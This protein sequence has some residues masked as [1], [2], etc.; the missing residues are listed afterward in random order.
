MDYVM[1]YVMDYSDGLCEASRTVA[2][3]NSCHWNRLLR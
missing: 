2:T 1:G 3:I